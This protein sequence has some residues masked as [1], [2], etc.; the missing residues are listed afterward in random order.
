MFLKKNLDEKISQIK[1]LKEEIKVLNSTIDEK[2]KTIEFLKG[3]EL[4][5]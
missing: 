4:N 3:C 5:E 2:N 1:A